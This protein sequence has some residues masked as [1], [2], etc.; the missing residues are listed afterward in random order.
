MS[1]S[2]P[3][4][5]ASIHH[6]T[7][8]P[9]QI[10]SHSALGNWDG[11]QPPPPP[12]T[13]T[14]SHAPA[15]APTHVTQHAPPPFHNNPPFP[16]VVASHPGGAPV[17]GP[18]TV[19]PAG[20][21]PPGGNSNFGGVPSHAAHGQYGRSL[22]YGS[23][24]GLRRPTSSVPSQYPPATATAQ[25]E[26]RGI[27]SVASGSHHTARPEY[28]SE[29]I[30]PTARVTLPCAECYLSSRQCDGV[31][32]SC[33]TCRAA[34]LGGTCDYRVVI[35]GRAITDA[36]KE[37]FRRFYETQSK[38]PTHEE[39]LFLQKQTGCRTEDIDQWYA[40]WS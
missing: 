21:L 20:Y 26:W 25:A 40:F 19:V 22:P 2:Y 11:S 1:F 3:N 24:P 17:H 13:R 14:R 18:H 27:S 31:R 12:P 34:G 39:R 32:P 28:A 23:A 36:A 29:H 6:I 7:P 35:D 10:S 37:V 9:N 5:D 33:G 8:S 4:G 16:P 38:V 30:S 15:A